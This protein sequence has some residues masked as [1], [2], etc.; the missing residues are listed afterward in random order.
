MKRFLY[1]L[2]LCML[3]VLYVQQVGAA[4][5]T[6]HK[7]YADMPLS[8]C[9]SCHK[10]QGIALSHDNDWA[11]KH[12]Q[13]PNWMGEHRALAS[14]GGT[15]CNDCHDQYFCLECHVGGGVDVS[16]GKTTSKKEFV[17]KSHRSNFLM[18]HPIK[19]LDNPQTCTRCHQQKY[20]IECHQRFPKGSQNIKSHFMLDANHQKYA[21]ALNEH[22]LEARRNLQSCQACHP[23]GDVCVQCH[24]QGK[25]NPHPKNW[26]SI[27]D[28]LRDRSKARTCVKCHT[29]GSY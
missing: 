6:S 4:V 14:K 28:G 17:P 19:S 22:P 18:I 20:C 24:S 5:K 7:D 25:A 2:L 13:D 1:G 26:S 27:K 12:H 16:L 3:T 11:G 10:E 15:N 21:P 9:N 29:P 8:E 23:D